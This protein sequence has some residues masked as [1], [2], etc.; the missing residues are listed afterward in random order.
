MLG[1]GFL[2]ISS[3]LG[4]LIEYTQMLIEI[5]KLKG[6][7]VGVLDE[8]RKGG[9]VTRVIFDCKQ[10]KVI[11]FL[12]KISGFFAG[13]KVISL[14]D[15]V[16]IDQ[17]GVVVRC[18]DAMLARGEIVRIEEILKKNAKLIG[19][20]VYGKDGKFLGFVSD[21]VVETQ[22]GDL[23]RIYVSFLWRRYIFP[24]TKIIKFSEKRVIVDTN[25]RVK[26]KEAAKNV[27]G[28]PEVA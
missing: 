24:I 2:G 3:T 1:G 4:N 5:S 14:V 23:L 8:A 7:P 13:E 25:S 27:L 21:A 18:A 12:V 22:T 28:V 11:G 19:L 16:S 17:N 6:L 9:N 20:R 26:I 15:V 10:V